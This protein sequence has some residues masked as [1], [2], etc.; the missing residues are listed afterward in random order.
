MLVLYFNRQFFEGINLI[1]GLFLFAGTILYFLKKQKINGTFIAH[2]GV[3]LLIIAITISSYNQVESI[4]I[5]HYGDQIKLAD[6]TFLF[7]N[8]N[9]LEAMNYNS[10]Y[11]NFLVFNETKDIIAGLFPEKRFYF[12]QGIYTTKAAIHSNFFGDIYAIIGDG[13]IKNGWYTR[14]FYNPLMPYVWIGG[15]CLVLGGVISLKNILKL[16]KLKLEKKII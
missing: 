14:F 15:L 12:Y 8:V 6:Y 10:L 5:L 2:L 16:R 13:S 9:N 1:I 7:R 4:Q 11:G 3:S